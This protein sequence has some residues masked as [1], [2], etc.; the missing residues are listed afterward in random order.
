MK[1]QDMFKRSRSQ[2]RSIEQAKTKTA[3]FLGKFWINAD[4]SVGDFLKKIWLGGGQR[5]FNIV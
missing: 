4:V 1:H 5:F 3:A 2:L